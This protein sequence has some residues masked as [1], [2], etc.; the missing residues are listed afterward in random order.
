[1]RENS[2]W[3]RS[4]MA[5]YYFQCFLSV[6]Q[7]Y[8]RLIGIKY[9]SHFSNQVKMK[10]LFNKEVIYLNIYIYIYIYIYNKAFLGQ[11]VDAT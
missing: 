9:G 3:F 8:S 10:M 1:M 7:F 11:N 4:K 2:G 5:T 6:L